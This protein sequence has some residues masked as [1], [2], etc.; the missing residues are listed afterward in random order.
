MDEFGPQLRPDPYPSAAA[1][2]RDAPPIL[3][4][5]AG[6]WSFG[7]YWGVWV[8]LVFE[9][10]RFHGFDDARLG[11]LYTCLSVVAVMVMLLVAPRL[12]PL[13]L[14][15][16]VTLSLLTLTVASVA[17][18][19]L[20][21]S[22]IALGFMLV[23]AGNGLID[24]YL[25]VA[26]QRAE[27]TSGK[28][29]LQW[30]HASYALGGVTGGAAAALVLAAGLDFRWGFAYAALALTATSIWNAATASRE[31]GP[32]GT[33]TTLSVSALSHT[34]A[35]WIPALAVLFAFL[36]EGSMDTWSGL[37]LREGLEAS[38]TTA[39]A[40][41][42]AFSG[43]IFFGRLFAGRVLFGLGARTTI[44][45]AGVGSAIAGST[46]VLTSEPWVVGVAFLL[47]GFSISAAA[48]AAFGLTETIDEDPTN[49][50]AAVTTVGYSGFIWS[51]PLLGWIAQTVD[52]RAAMAVVV[53][54]TFGLIV[55]GY[56]APRGEGAA[57]VSPRG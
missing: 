38:A 25:N 9:Y 5:L 3:P 36:V 10:Q 1:D 24:V 33:E 4:L 43:A 55:V 27:V 44:L 49:A 46:A 20:P 11:L 34:P 29:V 53:V 16:S 41:F 31:R 19:F 32:E 8:I 30:L 7:Q 6:Y 18:G 12:Q 48:P 47:L 26:A 13:R 54:G 57:R 42:M 2:G 50:I 52:L 51:P 21:G 56:L 17:I 37:Y 39:A 40:A 45:A 14:R 23:G 22:V 35:L 28:P 15:T